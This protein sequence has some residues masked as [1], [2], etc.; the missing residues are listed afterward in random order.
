MGDAPPE[1]AHA[2]AAIERAER[3]ARSEVRHD[4]AIAR[5]G[6]G[7]VAEE[8]LASGLLCFLLTPENPVETLRRAAVTRGDSDSIAC[9]AGAFAG[10]HLGIGAFP[11]QWKGQIE[12][13]SELERQSRGMGY[14][15]RGPASRARVTRTSW[16]K[17]RRWKDSS[18]HYSFRRAMFARVQPAMT[19]R[20]F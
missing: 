13:S 17:R 12:Y 10:A 14:R 3:L 5:L 6:E 18:L 2:L 19:S 7:W 8:A 11:A 9:L 20:N 1:S 4:L 15:S 16:S